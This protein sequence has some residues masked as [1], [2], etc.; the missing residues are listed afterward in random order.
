MLSSAR[1]VADALGADWPESADG[2]FSLDTLPPTSVGGLA[3]RYL[4]SA[5]GPSDSPSAE[6]DAAPDAPAAAPD[7][8][9][10]I[11]LPTLNALDDELAS[12][13]ANLTTLR[14]QTFGGGRTSHPTSHSVA[15]AAHSQPPQH[16]PSDSPGVDPP[17]GPPSVADAD[18]DEQ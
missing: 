16:S 1:R 13:L 5:G 6:R 15:P 14:E 12:A 18:D 17:I 2:A 3:M 10:D 7:M 4:E 11:D 9:F 8:Q